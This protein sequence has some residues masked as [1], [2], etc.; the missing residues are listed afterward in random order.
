MQRIYKTSVR[1]GVKTEPD[2]SL[3]NAVVQRGGGGDRAVVQARD[4]VSALQIFFA[5]LIVL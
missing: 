2:L 1:G 5:D 3:Y 4:K